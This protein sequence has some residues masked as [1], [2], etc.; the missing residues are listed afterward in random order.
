[1]PLTVRIRR[2]YTAREGRE[3]QVQKKEQTSHRSDPPKRKQG[4]TD[5]NLGFGP[6]FALAI[7]IACPLY[8]LAGK[9]H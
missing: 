9:I 8:L 2:S 6:A 4:R 3:V 1:M 5:S 7:W